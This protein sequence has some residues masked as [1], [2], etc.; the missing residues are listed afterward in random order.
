MSYHRTILESPSVSSGLQDWLNLSFGVWK[1]GKLALKHKNVFYPITEREL[2]LQ[3]KQS[4][5]NGYSGFKIDMEIESY[6]SQI[7]HFGQ[8]PEKVFKKLHLGK[9][10]VFRVTL[11]EFDT[12]LITTELS[13]KQN[14][15]FIFVSNVTFIGEKLILTQNSIFKEFKITKVMRNEDDIDYRLKI[16]REK[17]LKLNLCKK[18]IN[19]AK[20]DFDNSLEKIPTLYLDKVDWFFL[21]GYIDAAIRIFDVENGSI[22]KTIFPI[23]SVITCLSSNRDI[24]LAGTENGEV[25]TWQLSNLEENNP[26]IKKRFKISL[27]TQEL[28]TL[29]CVWRSPYFCTSSADGYLFLVNYKTGM[30]QKKLKNPNLGS[31]Q[32]VRIFLL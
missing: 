24:I 21:G 16:L 14:K 31:V 17:K 28:R 6:I 22:L 12:E 18:K 13:S 8:C 32:Q 5:S 10:Q 3:K 27:F 30:V 26:K 11:G 1:N 4:F 23:G 2:A 9:K 20:E 7:Y 15:N 19:L 29:L 25:L